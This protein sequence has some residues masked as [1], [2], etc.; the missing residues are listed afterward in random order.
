M[1]KDIAQ[2]LD[3]PTP[4][5]GLTSGRDIPKQW[6]TPPEITDIKEA[7]ELIF[8]QLVDPARITHLL[9]LI[10][11]GVPVSKIATLVAKQGFKEGLW[12]PDM[13]IM[14]M[15]PVAIMIIA[16]AREYGL[17]PVIARKDIQVAI[18][19]Q[20]KD[21]KRIQEKVNKEAPSNEELSVDTGTPSLLGSEM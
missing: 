6:E 11:Q 10:D 18:S 9:E 13:V 3:T 12:T 20:E 19:S 4:G 1:P 5:Q 21:I 2:F 17:T 14:L 16:I 7:R 15:E 8:T